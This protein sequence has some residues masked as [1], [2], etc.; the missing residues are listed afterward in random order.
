MTERTDKEKLLNDD[1]VDNSTTN[2]DDFTDYENQ[3]PKEHKHGVETRGMLSSSDANDTDG[4]SV[5][6]GDKLKN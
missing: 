5:R 6:D 3:E 4:H 1:R 2:R